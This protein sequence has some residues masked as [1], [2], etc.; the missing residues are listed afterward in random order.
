[1]KLFVLLVYIK[2]ETGCDFFLWVHRERCPDTSTQGPS[3]NSVLFVVANVYASVRLTRDVCWIGT[4]QRALLPKFFKSF[5]RFSGLFRKLWIRS[6]NSWRL[7]EVLGTIP[8]LSV[9]AVAPLPS[10]NLR[11]QFSAHCIGRVATALA[12]AR[13][14]LRMWLGVP[15]WVLGWGEVQ[16]WKGWCVCGSKE[17]ENRPSESASCC[18]NPAWNKFPLNYGLAHAQFCFSAEKR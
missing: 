4:A 15:T 13:A 5:Q 14:S 6:R 18:C 17:E 8:F 11:S 9:S 12:S 2:E 1:M 16:G 7:W 3:G 10:Q